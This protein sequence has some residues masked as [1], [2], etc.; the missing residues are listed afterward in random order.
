MD[1][2]LARLETLIIQQTSAHERLLSLLEHKRES[3]RTADRDQMTRCTEQENLVVQEISEL[4]KERLGLV[5]ELTLIVDP[6]AKAPMR[7]AELAQQLDE[8]GR[9]RLLVLRSQLL[10]RMKQVQRETAVVKRATESVVR[11]MQGLFQM[12][13]NAV[14]NGGVYSQRGAPPQHVLAVNTF[15]ATA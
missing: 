12:V 15:N 1:K 8:P 13:G 5:G 4:E 9:G 3:L 11:H 10:D 7:L 2:Q 14:G 6:S